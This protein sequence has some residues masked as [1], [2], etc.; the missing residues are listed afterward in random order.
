MKLPLHKALMIR[1]NLFRNILVAAEG[2]EPPSPSGRRILSTLC[3]PFHH[4]AIGN[5]DGIRTRISFASKD[6]LA[7]MRLCII[8]PLYLAGEEGFE[9]PPA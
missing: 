7:I 6:G 5:R 3:M 8:P 4:A 1:K 2:L 9:P